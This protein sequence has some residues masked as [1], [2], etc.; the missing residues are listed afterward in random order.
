MKKLLEDLRE[1][2][3]VAAW[4]AYMD[5]CR[6][7]GINPST[8]EGFL[9]AGQVRGT[10]LPQLEGA[11]LLCQWLM[12]K[13]P[14][15]LWKEGGWH[16]LHELQDA[17]NEA[18]NSTRVRVVEPCP[19]CTERYPLKLNQQYYI[20]DITE[21]KLFTKQLWCDDEVDMRHLRRGLVHLNSDGAVNHAK[22]LLGSNNESA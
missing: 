6:T 8:M 9:V 5:A 10:V 4:N 2:C 14:I 15:E 21:M 20:P 12:D 18:A 17:F 3:A 1:A 22:A 13:T 11:H 16:S 19:H 7:R